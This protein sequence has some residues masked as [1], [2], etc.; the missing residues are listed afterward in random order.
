MVIEMVNWND[1]MNMYSVAFYLTGSGEDE[2]IREKV[3]ADES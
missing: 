2:T 1:I 3:Y